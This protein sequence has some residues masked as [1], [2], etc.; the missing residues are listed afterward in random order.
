[1]KNR[2]VEN[3]MMYVLYVFGSCLLL[4]LGSIFRVSA[5]SIHIV[6]SRIANF[7]DVRAFLFVLLF[8]LLVLL[9]MRA[10]QDFRKAISLMV[11]GGSASAAQYRQCAR[12]VKAVMHTAVASGAAYAVI[13]AINLL[14]AMDLSSRSSVGP[15]AVSALLSIFYA[16]VIC[17]LLIPVVL[18]MKKGADEAKP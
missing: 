3:F 4:Y 10:I 5:G 14:Q 2:G 17:V 12:V 16:A 11:R 1:M 15:S 18:T 8:C 9:G 7:L 13:Q 6:P